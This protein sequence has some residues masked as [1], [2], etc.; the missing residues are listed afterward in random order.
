[1]ILNRGPLPWWRFSCRGAIN[2]SK[3]Y[4]RAKKIKRDDFLYDQGYVQ[5]NQTCLCIQYITLSPDV[6]NICQSHWYLL[7]DDVI[8]KESVPEKP[9]VI[10]HR[11]R[12]LEVLHPHS[13]IWT[14]PKWDRSQFDVCKSGN[15]DYCPF[16]IDWLSL[17]FSLEQK[18][19][20]FG[21]VTCN[22]TGVFYIL[23][24]TYGYFN[25]GKTHRMVWKR[26]VYE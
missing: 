1:M 4:M 26:L 6:L 12:S 24:Y 5:G 20:C 22:T 8:L 10:Y 11:A 14:N 23:S 21:N 19:R 7:T 2:L 9:A 25:V 18:R 16:L 15:C 3:P 17:T 13:S